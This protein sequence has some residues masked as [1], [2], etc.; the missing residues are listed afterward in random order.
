MFSEKQ[1]TEFS[2]AFYLLSG[3]KITKDKKY[4]IENRLGKYIGQGKTYPSF[5]AMLDSLI[6]QKS[7]KTKHLLI[8]ALT[9]NYSYFFRDIAHFRF[10]AYLLKNKKQE[11]GFPVR[12]W[13]AA[14]SSGE[15]L[16][17]IAITADLIIP[18]FTNSQVMI[19]G[20]D[21]SPKM[22]QTAGEGSYSATGMI[23][24][25]SPNI[26][27]RYFEKSGE[28]DGMY[29]IKGEIRKK[30]RIERLNLMGDY[31]FTKQFDVVFLRNILI[32]FNIEE[33]EILINKISNYIKPGGYLILGLSE[34]IRGMDIH[35]ESKKFSIYKKQ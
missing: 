30:V 28:E 23:Q 35:F 15:E 6:Y 2:N 9:T 26:L 24:K 34:N 21:I 17:S 29:T 31:S 11:D 8:N 5:S 18:G 10:L 32:Y 33:K 7:K 25:I 3:I 14:C 1:F 27:T 4:L 19:L 13:S 16:Y 12:I 20:S 22:I